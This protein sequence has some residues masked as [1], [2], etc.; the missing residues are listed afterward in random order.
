MKGTKKED[1]HRNVCDETKRVVVFL[2]LAA[3]LQSQLRQLPLTLYDCTLEA[4]DTQIFDCIGDGSFCCFYVKLCFEIRYDPLFGGVVM[5]SLFRC[6]VVTPLD[7]PRQAE[8][9]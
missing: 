7:G 3:T 5:A 8:A 9:E 4:R 6:H 2:S 1:Y